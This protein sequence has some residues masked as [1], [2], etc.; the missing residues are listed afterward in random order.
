MGCTLLDTVDEGKDS[1]HD[2][3]LLDVDGDPI[4]VAESLRYHLS[5]GTDTLIDWTTI[6]PPAGTGTI[7][8]SGIFNRISS[9]GKTQRFLTLYAIHN[10][11]KN[12]PQEI[13]YEIV[14]A[15]GII[16]TTPPTS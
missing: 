9:P 2:Y 12:L 8:I 10:G 5:D 3:E 6:S 15:V 16:P 7:E 11:G 14:P 13:E 1:S 4:S